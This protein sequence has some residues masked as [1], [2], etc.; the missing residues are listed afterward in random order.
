M[1]SGGAACGLMVV[2]EVSVYALGPREQPAVTGAADGRG[3]TVP[4]PWCRLGHSGNNFALGGVQPSR[5]SGKVPRSQDTFPARP[6]RMRRKARRKV[7]LGGYENHD[8]R[9]Y[10]R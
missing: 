5:G 7:S 1:A 4:L 10:T 2:A 9:R 3:M 6:D 8:V